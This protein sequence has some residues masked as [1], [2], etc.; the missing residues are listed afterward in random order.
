[1]IGYASWALK[2]L[3]VTNDF[4]PKVGGIQSYLF[5]LVSSLDPSWVRVLAPA[6]PGAAE[7]DAR[8]PF[9]VF[10]EPT[11]RLYPSPGLLRRICDLSAGMDVVQ[12]GY[13]LQSWV[14]APATQRQTGL[15]YVVFAHGAEVLFPLRIPGAARLLLWGTLKWA[16]EVLAVSEHTAAGVERYT[17][18]RVG[19]TVLRPIV[20]LEKFRP[21]GGYRAEVRARHGLAK[22]PVILCVSRLTA[23]KGQDRLIDVLPPLRRQFGARLLLAGEGPFGGSL[24]RR[25]RRRGVEK[26]I[27]FAGRVPDEML[28]S[29]YG[30]A[31]VFAMPARSRWLGVE[32]EGFGVVFVE[33]AAAGLPMVVGS[34]GGAREALQDGVTGFLVNGCSTPEIKQA[35]ARLIGDDRLRSRMGAAARER[36]V[37]LHDV[38]VVGERYRKVLERA[39]R[40]RKP[41]G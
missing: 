32:E 21:L 36:A 13:V 10:R 35:L 41:A 26:D 5:E 1:M 27:V 38:S 12:F 8:Q 16:A 28:P 33:A 18:G 4:P 6:Y 17:R 34:S 22:R 19:C 37:A 25:A 9:E 30:A 7:F 29:Y 24:L 40:Q 23:R 20:D 2:T 39:S 11:S 14:L 15:P 31:D 3:L